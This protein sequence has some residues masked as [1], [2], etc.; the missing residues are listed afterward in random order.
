MP[1]TYTDA[2]KRYYNANLDEMRQKQREAS[3]SYYA[4]HKEVILAQRKAKR[5][6]RRL[7]QLHA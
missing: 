4:E 7:A 3:A 1:S 5:L 6:A 2:H